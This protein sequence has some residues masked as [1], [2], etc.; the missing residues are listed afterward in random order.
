MLAPLLLLLG[1]SLS[2]PLPLSQPASCSPPF[3]SAHLP[4][5]LSVTSAALYSCS[6]D[7]FKPAGNAAPWSYCCKG[8]GEQ[9]KEGEQVGPP[10]GRGWRGWGAGWQSNSRQIIGSWHT[11]G[12]PECTPQEGVPPPARQGSTPSTLISPRASPVLALALPMPAAPH[13]VKSHTL[14]KKHTG[15]EPHS[16]QQPH[17]TGNPTWSNSLPTTSRSQRVAAAKSST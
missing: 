5:S 13:L 3:L 15:Q 14:V 2:V 1:P 10:R 11:L 6:L 8:E 16:G 4:C 9:E 12:L 7:L 17:I